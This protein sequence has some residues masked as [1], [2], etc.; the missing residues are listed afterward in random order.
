MKSPTKRD[1]QKAL[2]ATR[3][4][5]RVYRHAPKGYR[6]RCAITDVGRLI[7]TKAEE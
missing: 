6:I 2:K 7:K 3:A 1:W 5:Y 4:M